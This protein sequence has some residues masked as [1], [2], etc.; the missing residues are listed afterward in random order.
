VPA[1][2]L[3]SPEGLVVEPR[4]DL[5]DV[6][7]GGQA[8]HAHARPGR[9]PRL[10]R[11][12]FLAAAAC[13]AEVAPVQEIPG[14]CP[15]LPADGLYAT[16]RMPPV[17]PDRPAEYF[18]ASITSD[19]GMTSALDAWQGRTR[20]NIPVGDLVCEPAGW[21]CGWP[22]HQ[23]PATVEVAEAAIEICDGG[24]MDTVEGCLAFR[25]SSGG[26][27]CP[28]SAQLVELRDCRAD[29]SCPAVPR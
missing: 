11:W 25:S 14:P 7:T 17:P 24:P 28:W 8:R 3:G 19:A 22:W 12:A 13:G 15:V 23:D 27:F 26:L 5:G 18:R 9:A 20:A 4:G 29:P 1:W 6:R 21:N 16:F 2:V 10:A